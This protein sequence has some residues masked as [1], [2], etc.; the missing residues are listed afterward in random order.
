MSAMSRAAQLEAMA[1]S[2]FYGK[3][4][5]DKISIYE[6]SITCR[7]GWQGNRKAYGQHWD[8]LRLDAVYPLIVAATRAQDAE[9]L[10]ATLRRFGLSAVDLFA[11]AESWTTP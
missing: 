5:A 9:E 1:I 6:D 3:H 10:K 11:L 7:C 4:N 8:E 2:N